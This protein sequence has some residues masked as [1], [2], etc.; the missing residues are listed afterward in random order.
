MTAM[1]KKVVIDYLP[2]SVRHYRDGY[3]IVAVDV[4]RATTTA[5]SCVAAGWRCFPV[6]SIEFA[7]PLAAKLHHPLLVGE[8]GGNMPY[9]FDVTNSPAKLSSRPDMTRPIIL[10]SSSGTRLIAEAAGADAVYLACLRNWTAT[11]KYLAERHPRVA[12][13][14][15]GTRGEFREEDQ[16]CC[17]LIAGYLTDHGFESEDAQTTEVIERWKNAPF[18]AWLMSKSVKYLRESNQL[19]DLEFVQNHI[20]DLSAAFIMKHD[21]VTLVSA[22]G[23]RPEITE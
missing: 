3:A 4:I 1:A 15:A 5:I 10:L 22:N 20:D 18:D 8:L 19:D 14:G 13:L 6:P 23:G 7:L 9:G 21:E 17:A 12:V 2:E 11:A 16:M